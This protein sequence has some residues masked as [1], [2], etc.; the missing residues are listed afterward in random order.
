MKKIICLVL[1][2][3]MFCLSALAAMSFTDLAEGHWAYSYVSK[4]VSDGT[5]R[6]YEDGSFRPTNTV[7]RAEFVKML[8][9]GP[10]R[11]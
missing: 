9:V 11:R 5:V 4:L 8:G 3:S 7:T 10:E 2:F 1:V 6:G